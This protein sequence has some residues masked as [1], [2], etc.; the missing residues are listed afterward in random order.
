MVLFILM[1][2]TG[3]AVPVICMIPN[4]AVKFAAYIYIYITW[5]LYI[6]GCGRFNESHA[7]WRHL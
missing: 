2:L 7:H 1:V 4:H 3:L 6:L 5:F